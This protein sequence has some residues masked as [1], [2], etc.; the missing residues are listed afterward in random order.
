[1]SRKAEGAGGLTPVKGGKRR[2]TRIPFETESGFSSDEYRR[3][4]DV[5]N[6]VRSSHSFRDILK[7]GGNYG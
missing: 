3:L 2:R 4:T 5:M 7:Y 6:N 1:M